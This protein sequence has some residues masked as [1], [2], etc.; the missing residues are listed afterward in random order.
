[1][2]TTANKQHRAHLVHNGLRSYLPSTNP[3]VDSSSTARKA[4]LYRYSSVTTGRLSRI[5]H[6]FVFPYFPSRRLFH[7]ND[8]IVNTISFHTYVQQQR[9]VE[10]QSLPRTWRHPSILIT[11]RT[12]DMHIF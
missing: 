4:G 5:D 10:P 9:A 11:T 3:S 8:K 12:Y 2:P 7:H 6:S 1:V